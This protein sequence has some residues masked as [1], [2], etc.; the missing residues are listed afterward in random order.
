MGPGAGKRRKRKRRHEGNARE[1][2]C[3]VQAVAEKS[4]ITG[5][6]FSTKKRFQ[7]KPCVAKSSLPVISNVEFAVDRSFPP[8][9]AFNAANNT[10]EQA[11]AGF[12][13]A[14]RITC[15]MAA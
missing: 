10:L 6:Q 15:R 1:T 7:K 8:A 2:G 12:K 4:L 3:P 14:H 9:L 13:P 11:I 5:P